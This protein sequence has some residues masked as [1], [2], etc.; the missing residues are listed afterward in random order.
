MRNL[1]KY[2]IRVSKI[3]VFIIALTV[4]MDISSK[5]LELK[6]WYTKYGDFYDGEMDY[7]VLFFG[8]SHVL[9]GIDPMTLYGEYGIKS[10]NMAY[11][12]MSIPASYW[13]MMNALDYVEPK[14]VVL[15]CYLIDHPQKIIS[16]NYSSYHIPFDAFDFSITKAAAA[17][18]LLN[19]P[20]LDEGL[21]N[22]DISINE[23]K[24]PLSF[25]WNYSLYHSRW[26]SLTWRDFSP[27][28]NIYIDKGATLRC[29]T[30]QIKSAVNL[31]VEEWNGNTVAIDYI[32]K[33][34]NEC[35]KR[36]ITVVLMYLP[37]LGNQVPHSYR[38]EKIA[39][40]E[41]VWCIN[42]FRENVV[43][44]QTD[45]FDDRGHL[46]D[47]GAYKVTTY[48]G[49]LFT[50]QMQE[51]NIELSTEPDDKWDQEFRRYQE[52][53]QSRLLN[54]ENFETVVSMSRMP[55]YNTEII[56]AD[57]QSMK[58]FQFLYP[59]FSVNLRKED[60][61]EDPA[62]NIEFVYTNRDG[63]ITHNNFKVEF[64]QSGDNIFEITGFEKL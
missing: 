21:A 15:D 6:T 2:S 51:D 36:D 20:V 12:S 3:L 64:Q 61:G 57:E 46:N 29:G 50:E 30:Q 26:N 17:F 59:E 13:I 19:D 33:M 62:W 25:L 7:D 23:K 41:Q 49:E 60:E 18:D 9:N 58:A 42:F 54:E 34:I 55:L 56:A 24:T 31:D 16:S 14:M 39:E 43:N 32:Y 11:Q 45:F 5:T 1:R 52:D 48:L 63:T 44:Y 47:V 10:Y 35:K 22:G 38:V 4:V 40:E 53:N 28:A 8:T 37:C 27:E